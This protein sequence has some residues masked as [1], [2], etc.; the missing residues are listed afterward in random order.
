MIIVITNVERKAF[1]KGFRDRKRNDLVSDRT[2]DIKG[3]DD[4]K[5]FVWRR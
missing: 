5:F 1:M 4:E 2:N 3:G